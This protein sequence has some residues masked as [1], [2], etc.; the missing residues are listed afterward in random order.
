MLPHTLLPFLA[1]CVLL[2]ICMEL[3]LWPRK[4][5]LFQVL[6]LQLS[7]ANAVSRWEHMEQV[8]A[9]L[10]RLWTCSTPATL[11][12]KY[13]HAQLSPE[14]NNKASLLS[15]MP[16]R[17]SAKL[18]RS[19]KLLLQLLEW[20]LDSEEGVVCA[21]RW[22]EQL[23]TAILCQWAKEWCDLSRLKG[24]LFLTPPLQMPKTPKPKYNKPHSPKPHQILVFDLS[25]LFKWT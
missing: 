11:Q 14:V 6:N 4:L 15:E 1:G 22:G 25:L 10:A 20:V 24:I 2:Y 18:P 17:P 13:L 9:E 3:E 23:T 21:G 7:P 12:M 5:G 8:M 16:L 19:H